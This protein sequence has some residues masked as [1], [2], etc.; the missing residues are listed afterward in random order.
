MIPSRI[1]KITPLAYEKSEW[2]YILI[3][4]SEST[5][6]LCC[7]VHNNWSW[8]DIYSKPKFESTNTEFDSFIITELLPSKLI[9]KAV[10][11]D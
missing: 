7:F 9:G 3:S 2:K 10:I 5:M 1:S 8:I 11:H 4:K 6:Y